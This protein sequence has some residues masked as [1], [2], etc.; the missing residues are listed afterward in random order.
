MWCMGWIYKNYAP[1]GPVRTL[2]KVVMSVKTVRSSD[3]SVF[4]EYIFPSLGEFSSD[5]EVRTVAPSL[6]ALLRC[7]FGN[8]SPLKHSHA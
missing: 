4:P 6:S 5:E 7:V 2:T 3:I 1:P 8:G